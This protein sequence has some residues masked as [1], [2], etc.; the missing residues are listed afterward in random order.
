MIKEIFRY[1][2]FFIVCWIAILFCDL[3]AI[4]LFIDVAYS[5]D[6]LIEYIQ[7]WHVWGIN[8]KILQ[9][10]MHIYL[11]P[12][13]AI[14]TGFEYSDEYAISIYFLIRGGIVY[15]VTYLLIIGTI[16]DIKYIREEKEKEKNSNNN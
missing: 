16:D 12:I 6:Q 4:I 1:A 10:I 14:F 3:I 2:F 11:L 13:M 5:S 8:N 7:I 15:L 9:N